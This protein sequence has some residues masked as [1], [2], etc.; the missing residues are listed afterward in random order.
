[1]EADNKSN[2]NLFG[3]LIQ[4]IKDPFLVLD[5][6]GNILSFNKEASELLSLE[7]NKGDIF[8]Y[9][10][11][12]SA[13]EL[14]LLF[15]KKLPLQKLISINSR[16]ILMSGDEFDVKLIVNSYK[17]REENF[18]FCRIKKKENQIIIGGRTEILVKNEDLK[19]IIHNP[20]ILTVIEEIKSL[21]PFT[22]IGKE[23]I[24]K[25]INNFDELFWVQ[26]IDG[27]YQVL[28]DKLANSL[29][30]SVSQ[31]EGKSVA[32]FLPAHLID[33]HNSL[34]S[35]LKKSLNYV[36]VEGIPLKNY[37]SGDKYQTIEIP[38][39]DVDNNV[40]A[41]IGVTQSS[42]AV[43]KGISI[44]DIFASPADLL[45]FFPKPV[46][47][48]DKD[49]IFKQTTEEFR[50]LFETEFH[51]LRRLSYNRILPNE[52]VGIIDEFIL[53]SSD[54]KK[55]R[56]NNQSKFK[57]KYSGEISLQLSKVYNEKYELEGVAILIESV[58]ESI[59]LGKL[60]TRRGKMFDILIE[61]N[62]EP[63]FI[64]DTE[65][66]RFLE[67]NA[68]ALQLYGYSRDEFLQMDL[69]DLYTTEDIQSL[70]DT[71]KSEINE[72]K[73]S[74]P[75]RHK[76]K[77]GSSVFVELSK[78][79][80]KYKERD[81]HFN[82]IRDVTEK[83]KLE[84]KEKSFDSVFNKTDNL[85]FLTDPNGFITFVNDAACAVLGH[86]K[87]DFTDSSFASYLKDED[88]GTVNTSVFKSNV[89][90]EISLTV[91]MKSL[92][93]EFIEA[94][95]F[96][97]PVLNF[98]NEIESFTIIV[99]KKEEPV[100]ET[101]EI[102]KE[103]V[104]EKPIE[105][106]SQA[107]GKI[108]SSFLSGLFH[109]ILT[110]INV[111]L[112]FVQE[113]TE[114][115]DNLTPEQKESADIINQNRERLLE[116]MNSVVEYTNIEKGNVQ[117]NISDIAITEII[118][119]LHSNIAE[120][121]GSK[122]TEFGYGKISSS[123]KFKSDKAKFQHFINLLVKIAAS[124]SKEKKIYFSSYP[125]G[126]DKFIISVRDNYANTTKYLLDFYKIVFIT[127]EIDTAKNHGISRLNLR[128]VKALLK[129]LN[130]KFE[131]LGDGEKTNC[132][133]VFPVDFYLAAEEKQKASAKRE[134]EIEKAIKELSDE[135]DYGE[136]EVT[137]EFEA[138]EEEEIAGFEKVPVTEK[139]TEYEAKTIS[140][141][142]K[143]E[144]EYSSSSQ[145]SGKLDL[146]QLRCLY[147]E[148]QVDSQIL[149]KVQMKELKEIKFAVS[150]EE[151]L[152]ILDSD[153]F[154]FIVMDINL[155][156]EYNGLDALKIIQKMQGYENIPIIAVTAYVLP[157]DK[158]KFIA[159][160]F[161]D[162]ISKP[163]F[164]EKMVNVL[165]RIFSMKI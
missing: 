133:F 15:A 52:I 137:K 101:K 157:G 92:N 162:F 135:S 58:E 147:I 70:L 152:P 93:G 54:K 119:Y 22:F 42:S 103:V 82:I 89:R 131:I 8:S 68:A 35:Y 151:A 141:E 158:E 61:N 115:I 60:I 20:G 64:Y 11:D 62:P 69:T 29:G 98:K 163:I 144:N 53:S 150:F 2:G 43:N 37:R 41:I 4:H 50:K 77:D 122:K 17:E 16:F 114:S 155:Q 145:T 75:Y 160:G 164:R 105:K 129:I 140:G 7:N 6:D 154:D 108:D 165:E 57:R 24:Q 161:D 23:K 117:F 84:K 36:I 49:G 106:T 148:D 14:K 51:D 107:S 80:F 79:I 125:E 96:A 81:A 78:I 66:L 73:F 121:T 30:I 94:E 90:E 39:S 31:V 27:N 5:V 109:E 59:D 38:L 112:G 149:F 32:S 139:E 127:G 63:I 18:I 111:I 44:S 56:L 40:I 21:Y 159:A 130:G 9:L 26:D 113:L 91:S 153:H 120:F 46:A 110:P 86:S 95:L 74:G 76:K 87:E 65:N 128:L 47:I 12:A 28:N 25:A 19:E 10:D 99:K 156:G 123:L 34:V 100:V 138:A 55:Y 71:S 85:V 72:R 126:N 1:M 48:I 102:I 33:F 134:D 13:E 45:Q 143:K 67:V 3:S 124:V 116:T 146:S 132:R 136:L 104:I 97:V 142:I 118:E 83:L 88:R